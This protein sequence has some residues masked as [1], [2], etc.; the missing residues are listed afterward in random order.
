MPS[1]KIL[2]VTLVSWLGWMTRVL[3]QISGLLCATWLLG[4][5]EML[6]LLMWFR[7]WLIGISTSSV[8]TCV[9]L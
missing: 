8:L 7:V 2:V 5:C 6:L 9:L 3:A 1:E 4:V